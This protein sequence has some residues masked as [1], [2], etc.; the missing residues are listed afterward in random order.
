[1]P[2]DVKDLEI[3]RDCLERSQSPRIGLFV[4]ETSA[5]LYFHLV[6]CDSVCCPVLR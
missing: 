6:S 1:M 2:F 3:T 5:P 4:G